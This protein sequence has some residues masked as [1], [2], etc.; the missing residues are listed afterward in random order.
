MSLENVRA[1]FDC[2]KLSSHAVAT[3]VVVVFVVLLVIFH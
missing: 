3:V 1:G 2:V